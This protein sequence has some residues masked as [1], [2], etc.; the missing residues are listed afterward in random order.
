MA[1]LP[2]SLLFVAGVFYVTV[3]PASFTLIAGQTKQLVA[4][5]TYSDGSTKDVSASASW[6]SSNASIATVSATGLAISLMSGA[7]KHLGRNLWD[8]RNQSK[9]SDRHQCADR[10]LGCDSEEA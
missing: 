7:S 9:W 8:L 2:V 3:T 6:S 1:V 10:G 4:T 5:A